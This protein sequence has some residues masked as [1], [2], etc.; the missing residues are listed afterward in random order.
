M[1]SR[2]SVAASAAVIAMFLVSVYPAFGQPAL[3]DKAKAWEYVGN[4]Q[5]KVCHNSKEEGQ[6]WTVWKGM[7]HAKAFQTLA[8]DKA[9]EAAKAKGLTKPPQ[10]SPE[11]LRC[12]V[13]GYDVAKAAAPAKIKPE[14]GVQCES[15]HGPSS[16]H[17]KDGQTLK[18]HKDQVGQIDIKA[19]RVAIDENICKGCH[20]ADSPT[21]NPEKYTLENGQKVG[22]DFKQ[23]SAKIA[24]KW[25]EGVIEKKYDGK[26]PK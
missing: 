14:D 24:H 11:C 7:E 15:C 19:N 20:N 9:K 16:A 18:F 10:E 22:F 13:T 1:K 21:W 4:T 2:L 26:Y 8:S 3:P 25:P 5:C 23:A 17:L 12:H 6:Q